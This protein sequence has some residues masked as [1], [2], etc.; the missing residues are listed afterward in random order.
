MLNN[1]KFIE[2][3]RKIHGNKYDYSKV[4]YIGALKKIIIVC[5]EHG[6]FEQIPN[7]HLMKYRLV[8]CPE[9]GKIK[10]IKYRTS[11]IETFIKKSKIIHEDKY[12]YSKF[13][14]TRSHEK[15]IIICPA[16]GEFLQDPHIHLSGSGCPKCSGNF[17]NLN[18][19]LENSK[20]K[21]G[22][23]YDYSKFKYTRSHEKSIIICPKHGEF[24]QSPSNHLLYGCP[25][26]ANNYSDKYH[27]IE[28]SK[29][30]HDNK[31][32]YSKVKYVNNKNNIIIICPEHGE[33]SQRPDNHLSGNGCP[34]CKN[35]WGERIIYNILNEY[36]ISH[37]RQ[38]KF[39]NLKNKN[40]LRFDFYVPVLNVCI[41]YDGRQH[42]Y[43]IDHWGGEA[44]LK[45]I[46][47]TDR[48]KKEYCEKYNIPLLRLTHE[49]N[50]EDIKIKLLNFLNIS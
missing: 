15:S 7:N 31:Y 41:E 43:P 10:R 27:F 24:L 11:N 25:K 19:F 49:D 37:V 33:F 6:D 3:A 38:K 39:K 21:H 14:Y 20:M 35:S 26:C 46:Q 30:I 29:K 16:H 45:Y 18:Y 13:K 28:K 12:D 17:S 2:K 44:G 47:N 8:G 48:L 23:K 36:N 50:I 22:N 9:C 42:F 5:P 32:D 4:N 34:I 40:L 1:I